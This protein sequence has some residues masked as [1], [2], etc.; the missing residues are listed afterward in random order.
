VISRRWGEGAVCGNWLDLGGGAGRK[1]YTAWNSRLSR[2]YPD[3]P[4]PR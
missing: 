3:T 2:G 1:A 4:L